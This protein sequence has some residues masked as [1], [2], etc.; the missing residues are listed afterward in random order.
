MKVVVEDAN[1]LL[2][3]LN[4]GILGLW[5]GLEFEHCTTHLVWQE[6]SVTAQRRQ[7]QPFIDSGLIR[8]NEVTP[9]SWD[10]IVAF[11]VTAGVS[12]P[13]SSVWLLAKKEN[14]ILLSGDSKLRKSAKTTGVDVRGVLWVLDEL[15]SRDKLSGNAAVK[16]LKKITD[17]GAF[18]P[19]DE[20]RARISSWISPKA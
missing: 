9:D 17:A 16:A 7:V 13:D 10:Q 11:S 15:V 6:I 12:I 19:A 1:V 5:L 8:L 4:G 2:D 14:A 18:L 3:L 20:C